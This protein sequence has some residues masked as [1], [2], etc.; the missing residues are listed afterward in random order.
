MKNSA[1]K[2][3]SQLIQDGKWMK[4]HASAVARPGYYPSFIMTKITNVAF[5]CFSKSFLSP[6]LHPP[7]R[8]THGP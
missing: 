6:P 8:L 4:N 7:G 2:I 5:L 1:T 3:D